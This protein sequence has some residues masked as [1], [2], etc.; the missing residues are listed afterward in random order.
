MSTLT[1]LSQKRAVKPRKAERPV[2]VRLAGEH[3]DFL[4]ALATVDGTT[5]AEQLRLAA[6]TYV[7]DRRN[8]PQLEEQIRAAQNRNRATLAAL[9]EGDD[10]YFQGQDD[11]H[12]ETHGKGK[13]VTFRAP[14]SLVGYL[15]GLAVLDDST[16]AEQL[17]NAV[18]IYVNARR[19]D[20]NL[21]SL[22]EA[23]QAGRDRL[24]EKLVSTQ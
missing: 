20:P 7:H 12:R 9:K 21:A 1:L 8:S 19:K 6:E 15:T 11:P 2:T 13:S 10:T 5:A 24:L 22:I 4:A 3:V 17:R 14:Q 18:N 16:L 23:S